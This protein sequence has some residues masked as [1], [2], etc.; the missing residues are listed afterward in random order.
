MKTTWRLTAAALALMT[1][2]CVDAYD[3][4]YPTGS[5]SAPRYY[6]PAYPSTVYVS[7][8]PVVVTRTQYVVVPAYHPRH[9]H[10]RH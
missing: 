8:P 1:G 3:T 10:H 9:R 7:Q 6:S 2:G 5:Y 4:S